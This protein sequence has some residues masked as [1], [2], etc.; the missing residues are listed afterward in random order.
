MDAMGESTG[1]VSRNRGVDLREELDTDRDIWWT[2]VQALLQA[3]EAERRAIEEYLHL[4]RGDFDGSLE[5][6]DV[7]THID[8]ALQHHRRAIND[9]QLAKQTV[10]ELRDEH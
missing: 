1:S 4:L 7:D 6:R 9:L 8:T 5:D 3:N 10:E 2:G